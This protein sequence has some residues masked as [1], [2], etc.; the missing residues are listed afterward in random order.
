MNDKLLFLYVESSIENMLISQLI[1]TAVR[2]FGSY[3][4]FFITRQEHVHGLL[5]FV[6][7]EEKDDDDDDP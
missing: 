6:E 2:N 4:R 1:D 5:N 7:E 3:F